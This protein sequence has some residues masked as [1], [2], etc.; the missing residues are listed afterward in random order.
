MDAKIAPQLGTVQETLL[1]PLYGRAAEARDPD[2]LIDDPAAVEMVEAIDYDFARF[3]GKP[4]L[5]G[6]TLRTRIIDHWVRGFLAEHPA[7]TV[8]E[9]GAGLNTRFDR[10][11]N[12]R[13]HWLDFD[14]PDAVELR[15]NF[16]PDQAAEGRRT[17]QAASVLDTAWQDTA[18]ELPGP[19]FLAAE[20]VL[21]FLTEEQVRDVVTR[22]AA[23]FPG[24][25]LVTD[26][27]AASMV[28]NQ[29]QH[30]ALSLVA[31]RMNWSCDDP[32][33]VE[34]WAPGI[35]LL[36]S[37]TLASLPTELVETFSEP[38]QAMLRQLASASEEA[39][40]AYRI[41]LFRLG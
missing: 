33:T 12:G 26:T 4:S 11:D 13:V 18:A 40:S 41:N 14:L 16:L 28:E 3:D 7:A 10:V 25:L 32:K 39:V 30:D 2:G 5:I 20:A 22:L 8:I 24:A 17:T 9:I 36:E 38:R 1:I 19:Y 29:D 23:R 31:A 27:A 21:P 34:D 15:R 6:A 37:V 35:R